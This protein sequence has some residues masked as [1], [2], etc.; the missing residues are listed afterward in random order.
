MDEPAGRPHSPF[1]ALL[2][3]EWLDA[4]PERPR[5]RMP[6]RDQLRQPVGLLHGGAIASLV[7]ATCTRATADAVLEDGREASCGSVALSFIR[8]ITEGYA[9]A[10]ARARH[11][12][13]TTWVWEVDVIDA[14]ERLCS[15]AKV[16][17]AVSRR[18]DS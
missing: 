16:T 6:L 1:E 10:Q 12:G 18:S 9:E 8:P 5:A 11:R 4:G 2:G 15:L 13:R 14:E 17:V 7:T 3:L